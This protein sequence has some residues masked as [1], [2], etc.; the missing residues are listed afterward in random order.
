MND[1]PVAQRTEHGASTPGAAGSTPAGRA[2]PEKLCVFCTHFE[3]ED[4]GPVYSTI[5]GCDPARMN[6][7]KQHWTQC[8][9][10]NSEDDF[11]ANI[12]RAATCPDYD[13]VRP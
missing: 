12:L 2:T 5:S 7:R 3:M 1:A 13:Q 9:G 11:R 4:E 8:V 10:F 6:C